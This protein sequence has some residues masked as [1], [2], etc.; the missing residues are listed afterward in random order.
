MYLLIL[1]GEDEDTEEVEEKE[2]RS[3][4]GRHKRNA[5][6]PGGQTASLLQS[7][8]AR[9][10]S[11]DAT[12]LREVSERPRYGACRAGAGAA[13]TWPGPRVQPPQR[14][15]ATLTAP[16]PIDTKGYFVSLLRM[17]Y[18]GDLPQPAKSTRVNQ[19]QISIQRDSR[20]SHAPTAAWE[21]ERSS[22]RRKQ[23]SS[24]TQT[25]RLNRPLLGTGQIYLYTKKHEIT[26][27]FFNTAA[28]SAGTSSGERKVTAFHLTRLCPHLSVV[29]NTQYALVDVAVCIFLSICLVGMKLYTDQPVSS[30][31]PP[32]RDKINGEEKARS[33]RRDWTDAPPPAP[34]ATQPHDDGLITTNRSL[35]N[36]Y[37]VPFTNEQFA[38]F[39]KFPAMPVDIRSPLMQQ[40]YD[41]QLRD[42]AASLTRPRSRRAL[43]ALERPTRL[44]PP[45]RLPARGSP[46][47]GAPIEEATSS[48]AS[49]GSEAADT[50]E[51]N[52][53]GES[54]RVE[55]PAERLLHARAGWLQRRG[56]GGWS[57]HWF[58]LRGAALLYFRDP[59]AEHR[60]LMD[61]VIDL[62]GVA[63]VVEL[64]TSASTNG[65]AFETEIWDGRHIILS[66]VTAGI[67][68]NWVSAIRRTAGLPDSGSLSLMLREDNADHASESST[69][70]ITPIT[71]A[72]PRSGPFS[73]DEE[74]RTASEG[75]RRD[76]ADWGDMAPQPPPSPIFN[77]TPISK[78][79]DKVRARGC[80][81]ALSR[82][83]ASKGEFD[84]I[85]STKE[86]EHITEEIEEQEKPTEPRKRSYTSTIDKQSIEIDD[87]RKQLQQALNDVNAAEC[88]LA[89]LRKIKAES[90]LREKK[91][92]E[93]VAVLH[94][95]EE[96]LCART[97]EAE[98]LDAIKEL[99]GQDKTLWETKL[100]E[101]QNFLKES[102]EHCELL[103]RQL[104]SAQETIQQLQREL[105]DLNDRLH[106]S[107]KENDKL[108]VRIRELE[109]KLTAESPTKEKRKTIGSLSELAN[110][111]Q[112]L[113]F[114][115]IERNKLIEEYIELRARFTKAIQ[116]I[117]AMKKELRE[118]HSM[119]DE[120]EVTNLKLR[121]EMKLREQCSNSE[122]DLMAARILDLTQKLTASDKQVRSLKHKI[123]K[124]ESREKRRSLSLKGR[125]SF[126]LSKEV[127]EKLTELEN[128][129]TLLETGEPA[130]IINTPT[131]ILTSTKEKSTKSDNT[132]DEKRMKRLAA[133]LRRKSLDSA[134]SSEPMKML[135]R[136]S[137]LETKI[138]SALENRRDVANSCESLSQSTRS[139]NS[140]SLADTPEGSTIGT[141]SQRHLLDRLQSLENVVI[142]SREKVNE[143]LCQMSA[144]RAAKSRR[145]PSPSVEKKYSIRSMEKCLTDVS[146]SLQECFDK[147]V[148]NTD[149]NT[150]LEINDNVAEVVIQLEEQLR[151]K[152]L[153][154]SKKK[155]SLYEA[156]ELTQ[157]KSLEILAEKLAYEAVLISRIQEALESSDG[158]RFFA[159]LIKSEII[160]TSQ[161]IDNLK[162]KV[163][164]DGSKN[165]NSTKSS[166]DYL[167]RILSRNIDIMSNNKEV[168][169]L[170]KS[171]L[172]IQSAD[173]DALK[174]SQKQITEAVEKYKSEKLAELSS[175][176]ACETLNYVS[177]DD[178]DFEQ[179]RMNIEA[180][181]VR[182]A[183]SAARDAL[184]AELVQAEVTRAL[185]R[186]AQL[187]EQR[188]DEARECRLT[189]S[190]Q[191]RADLELWW[192]AAHDHLRTEMDAAVRDIGARY[193]ECLACPSRRT[194][195]ECSPGLDS[196]ALL[197]QLADVLAQKAL[198]DA[199]IAVVEGT[200][201][202][203][204]PEE[205][206]A[207]SGGGGEHVI[208]S[209]ET[210]PSQEAE[211]VYLFQHFSSE[212]RA[213]F[214]SDCSGNSDDLTNIGRS[215]ERVE[216]QLAA[217]QRHLG[218][219]DAPPTAAEL[220][221]P[222]SA[223]TAAAASPLSPLRAAAQRCESLKRRV[224]AL[225]ALVPCQHCKQLQEALDRL[226]SERARGESA[227]AQQAS[228]LAAARRARQQLQAQHERE[229]AQLRERAR[230]LERRLAALDSEYSAQLDSLRA[231]YQCVQ[232]AVAADTHG[233][234]LRARYQQEIEQL[235]A[236]C[237]KGLLAMESSHRRIV[238][239]L[240]EKHRAERDQLRLDKEQALAE[241]TR[242]TLA[243]L[244]AMRKAHESEVRR[245]V[246]KFKAEFLSRGVQ[247]SDINQ[248]STKHQQEMEEIKREILSLSEKY[249]VKC[250]ESAA[251]EER[252]AA[253]TAQLA[254]AQQHIMQ[255]DA[256]QIFH[257]RCDQREHM[258]C[259]PIGRVPRAR[260][261]PRRRRARARAP[262]H[263]RGRTSRGQVKQY[264][265][266]H[267]LRV[268]AL[269]RSGTRR[270]RT[271]TKATPSG[272]TTYRRSP[273][274][275]SRRAVSEPTIKSK[276]T[277][278]ITLKVGNPGETA[279]NVTTQ[280]IVRE[281]RNH[282]K[283]T[284]VARPELNARRCSGAPLVGMVAERKK[285]FEA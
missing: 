8:T 192:R 90:A 72:T 63:R 234:G 107:V 262:P 130:P 195:K 174:S 110:I 151:N 109:G 126:T 118:S 10:Y 61:G 178:M 19:I 218:G 20:A 241:E 40:P 18:G 7:A 55:L 69:S 93:L 171:E 27:I 272:T 213:L 169:G 251:L 229:R 221:V 98:N 2:T 41:E 97:K 261:P 62:S 217:V 193:R 38:S 119:Y 184:G 189:L 157:R 198:V 206:G 235:R 148:V 279:A 95:K 35:K 168:K 133:R 85:D 172:I 208:A 30:A 76:S 79:K 180:A 87:L 267:L 211:F 48:S 281:A 106:K 127:E 47:G 32:T 236:L 185:N 49:E 125:E 15:I 11:A 285:L 282:K 59:H 94:Q 197:Q 83:D 214:S 153:E 201:R 37:P 42:I 1:L 268:P 23:S 245:E 58:V 240:E 179:Q 88:E 181:R 187:C 227:F 52:D 162:Y 231:A 64:P 22:D 81:Q 13:T 258:P 166:L 254:H 74:Y 86:K 131:K 284:T 276:L 117:N 16:A 230:R 257:K 225:A 44:P 176:L 50:G 210:D 108:Y 114:D 274:R 199:R 271:P 222:A 101:T 253:A 60:G 3:D 190:A 277:A 154:I 238:R 246:D 138:V 34:A 12:T 269:E 68:A 5:T 247:P 259:S 264:S 265:K 24:W 232:S 129:L 65:Y 260:P 56:P 77:R 46:D 143:C 51:T 91:M 146:K 104:S 255:L 160:E 121:N 203:A 75:G 158:S 250:V 139:S 29:Y 25:P 252:L 215:L 70:P 140:P 136:L 82:T 145:S 112:D 89:R 244:D 39:T 216:A 132:I 191:D 115:T 105:S 111:N 219:D 124:T 237:E 92:E 202:A 239:D 256:R 196:R 73:S 200:Y 228:A 233:D 144:M 249:S 99:Y 43:P 96:Q 17:H 175:A 164:G 156:G 224:E 31:S 223:A 54:G 28:S 147:C 45:D 102:T 150:N 21:L 149:Q 177:P 103:T 165:I 122:I 263:G 67:R 120:L 57:R 212:C 14:E 6:F 142:H 226:Q 134:T 170:R 182:E 275:S 161:L 186:A 242:A 280:D 283:L 4:T 123:Q 209:L 183:W 100:T 207:A 163:T 113:N 173:L 135:V 137:S 80:H 53:N 9:K 155:A 116:E 248:I 220:L 159:R 266:K 71:P 273:L 36:N 278:S 152:L 141:Q 78:V 205:R 270:G 188:L 26:K 167:A 84:E 204:A 243:A 33:R 128:K 194:V 66:A